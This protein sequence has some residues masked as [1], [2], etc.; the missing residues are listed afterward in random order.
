MF[1]AAC[2][3]STSGANAQALA[4]KPFYERHPLAVA[5]AV[6]TVKTASADVLIQT[7][8]E[9]CESVD[10]KRVALFTAFGSCY[11]G[12]FQYLLYVKCFSWWFDAARLSKMSLRAIFAEPGGAA[13]NNWLKQMGFD[14][15]LHGHLFFPSYYAFKISIMGQPTIMEGRPFGEILS[16]ALAKY[17]QNM[18]EDWI[19][20][21]KVWI[22]GDIVAFGM[23]PLWARLPT[24]NAIS[25]LYVLVLSSMRGAA[26]PEPDDEV[27]V[28]KPKRRV[29][30]NHGT[31]T[32]GVQR[33]S[34]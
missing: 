6:A 11:F 18:V 32:E 23:V 3:P 29:T 15:L 22:V 20:F 28:K 19:G 16:E 33:A 24:N 7:Q 8:V 34:A 2:R 25:F 13:R 5:V 30:M 10:Y 17:K 9:K 14:L 31:G 1:R 26:E 4:P 27:P 21:W 12:A